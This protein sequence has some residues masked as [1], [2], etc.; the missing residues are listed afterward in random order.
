LKFANK[1]LSNIYHLNQEFPTFFNSRAPAN[2]QKNL[3][4]IKANHINKEEIK[5]GNK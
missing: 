5:I 4:A 2:E 1:N 3:L